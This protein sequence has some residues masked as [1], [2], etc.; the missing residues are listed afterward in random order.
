[1]SGQAEVPGLPLPATALVGREDE[2]V[3]LRTLL[4]APAARLVTLTGPG[5]SGKTRLALALAADLATR[6][7]DGVRFVPLANV[8]D[9]ALVISAIGG[10]LGLREETG[11]S[12]LIALQ[13]YMRQK[14]LLLVLDNFEQV[15]AAAPYLADLLATAPGIKILVTSR[16]ALHL[17]GE[18]EFPLA[19]LALPPTAPAGNL[20]ALPDLAAYPAIRLFVDRARDVH[21]DFAL[22]EANAASIAG[23]C[24]AVDGLPLA[25]ELAA[26]RTRILSPAALLA[27]LGHRLDVLAGGA[28]DLPLR[29]QTLRDAIAWS[30]ELLAPPDQALFR[31]LSV[32]SGGAVLEAIEVVAGPLVADAAAGAGVPVPDLLRQIE[33]LVDQNLLRQREDPDGEP[34]FWM[35]ATIREFATEQLEVLGE[36]SATRDRHRA[37][38]YALASEANSYL[39]GSDQVP[40]FERLELEH[41]NLR[42]ALDWCE[43]TDEGASRGLELAAE[44]WWF[45]AVRGYWS[46][47]YARLKALLARA[48]AH[49]A[50]RA[51]PQT[52]LSS[53][54]II[55]DPSPPARAHCP[56]LYTPGQHSFSAG[57]TS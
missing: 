31:A 53:A 39:R 38:F 49:L 35:L 3:A 55:G 4:T 43:R 10:S 22:T 16:A 51:C 46:E 44:L 21:P 37:W 41:D 27:R 9:P 14:R 50:W 33:T 19:P 6:F 1:M 13:D 7:P 8:T 48:P 54:R 5:G 45:W 47:A 36:G 40:W 23:I 18:R 2:L 32:F 15:T 42:A 29:Q 34:R 20:P 24:M 28:R 56:K 17:R 25:I 57:A 12:L 26:A 52:K 30:Y 11:R